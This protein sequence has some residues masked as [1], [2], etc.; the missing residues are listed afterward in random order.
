MSPASAGSVIERS[1]ST[2]VH[3]L[4]NARLLPPCDNAQQRWGTGELGQERI[5]SRR[6]LR[7]GSV[8]DFVTGIRPARPRPG[9]AANRVPV[10]LIQL[11]RSVEHL[12]SGK[13]RQEELVKVFGRHRCSVRIIAEKRSDRAS[14]LFQLGDHLCA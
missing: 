1:N 2:L 9:M 4:F 5:M 8:G 12:G 13:F 10:R 7:A 3:S 6:L 14:E 11:D